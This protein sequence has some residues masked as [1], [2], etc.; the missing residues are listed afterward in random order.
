MT[1]SPAVGRSRPV[2]ILMVVLLPAPLGPRKPK[3]RPRATLKVRPFT[4]VVL[5]KTLVSPRTTMAAV[6]SGGAGPVTSDMAGSIERK[7]GGR[8]I[9]LG[10]R[11]LLDEVLGEYG[12]SERHA[13]DIAAPPAAV[14]DAV[15]SLTAD[16][17]PLVRALLAVRSL[18]SRLLRRHGRSAGPARPVVEEMTRSGFFPLG[19]DPGRELVVGIVGR[20]WQACPVHAEIASADGFRAFDAPGWAKAAMNFR[21]GPLPDGR[22]RLT[23][24]TRIVATDAAARRRFGAYWLV[25]GPGARPSAGSGCGR[26]GVVRNVHRR[27]RPTPAGGSHRAYGH[28][29]PGDLNSL[30]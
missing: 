22:T 11:V 4:A 12:W 19:E 18:P 3:K 20:F 30:S 5:P 9:A 8:R 23:T 28:G 24:E 26:C 13:I 16:E 29:A 2:S 10:C 14:L 21:V 25:V 15:R 6:A 1:T 17:M 27:P 7:R